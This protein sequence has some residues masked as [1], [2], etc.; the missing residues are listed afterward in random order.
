MKQ[1]ADGPR[2]AQAS[3]LSAAQC[4]SQPLSPRA[5]S[6][7]PAVDDSLSFALVRLGSGS[8]K[9]VTGNPKFDSLG[10]S[11]GDR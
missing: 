11:L 2:W 3:V 8:A 9:M 4:R 5:T 6:A 1:A 10:V 7:S